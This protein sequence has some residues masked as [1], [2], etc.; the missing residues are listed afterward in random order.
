VKWLVRSVFGLLALGLLGLLVWSYWPRPLAVE[1]AEV[2]AGPLQVEV[3]EDGKVR[4]QDRYTVS[5]PLPGV[6]SRPVLSAGDAVQPGSVLARLRPLRPQLLDPRARAEAQA[7][8]DAAVDAQRRAGAT[9]AQAEVA[10]KDAERELQRTA[11]LQASGAATG[12]EL[13]RVRSNVQL[14]R[15][16]LLAARAGVREAGHEVEVA[17][18]A[19]GATAG[20]GGPQEMLPLTSPIQGKILKV[21]QESESAVSPGMPL[22]EI[23]DPAALEVVVDLLTTDA[24]RVRPGMRAV[25]DH[26]GGAERLAA[27]VRRVEPS[28]FTR[29]SPLGVE[30]QRVNAVLDLDEAARARVGAGAGAEG[31]LGDGYAVNARIVVWEREKVLR[32]PRSA[33]FRR[34]DGWAAFAVVEGRARLREVEL[35]QQGLLLGEVLRGLAEGDQLVAHPPETLRDGQKIVPR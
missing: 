18:A 9:L 13:D 15:A 27:R 34:G 30:E 26:W 22:F 7:R 33:L 5:A 2:T 21:I 28:A 31:S 10:V 35:G 6:V 17:R 16:E 3:E 32:A 11:S 23:G 1:V 29:V 12:Q 4:V 24:V 20:S 14:R 19:L 25:L 8:R